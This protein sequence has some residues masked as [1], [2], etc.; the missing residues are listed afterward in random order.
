M[1]TVSPSLLILDNCTSH[2]E[3][4]EL[5]SEENI[6]ILFL[7]PHSSHITQPLDLNLFSS[8]KKKY[9]NELKKNNINN[10][11]NNKSLKN[12][13]SILKAFHDSVC[14]STII[15][16][17]RRFGLSLKI[18]QDEIVAYFNPNE[19]LCANEF[20]IIFE[21]FEAPIKKSEKKNFKIQNK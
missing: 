1:K 12:L 7:P 18:S 17:F 16:S 14:P 10:F 21:N 19:S 5:C 11:T 15:S 8:L 6:R 3:V 4:E 2:K 20:N 9:I 13:I